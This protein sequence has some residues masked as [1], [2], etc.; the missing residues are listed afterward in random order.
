[1]KALGTSWP[2]LALYKKERKRGLGARMKI[3][4]CHMLQRYLKVLKA[5]VRQMDETAGSTEKG[6]TVS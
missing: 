2:R 4:A 6:L 3:A 1:M 5:A